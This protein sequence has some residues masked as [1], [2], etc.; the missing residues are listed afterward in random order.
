MKKLYFLNLTAFLI[1]TRDHA[2]TRPFSS[3]ISALESCFHH[4][5]QSDNIS[6]QIEGRSRHVNLAIFH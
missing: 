5:L 3:G 1:I 2:H 6:Q 4:G